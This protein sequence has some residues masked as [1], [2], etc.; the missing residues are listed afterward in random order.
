[1]IPPSTALLTKASVLA[2]VGG[3]SDTDRMHLDLATLI[4]VEKDVVVVEG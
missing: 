2:S 3:G 1:M 4:C